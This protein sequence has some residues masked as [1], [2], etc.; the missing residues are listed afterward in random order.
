M[1]EKILAGDIHG[2]SRALSLVEGDGGQGT[3]DLLK[4]LYPHSSESLVVGITGGTGT[5]KSTLVEELAQEFLKTTQKVGIIAVDPTSPFSGGAI[6]GDRIRMQSLATNPAVF[7]RSMATRGRLGGLSAAVNDGLVVL[8]AAGYGVLLVETVGVGQ[9]EVEVAETADV[10]V[11]IL[12]PGMGDDVQTIKA[13]IM[14]IGDIFVLNKADRDGAEKARL[15]L[16]SLRSLM[17]PRDGWVPPILETVAIRGQGLS[18]LVSA[19]LDFESTV[20]ETGS[21]AKRKVAFCRAHLVDLLRDRLA[22]EILS[23]IGDQELH[24]YAERVAAHELDPY[25]AVEELVSLGKG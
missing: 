18:E 14:E 22:D 5:G 6:L 7:I 20:V 24:N 13:G 16:D 19:I 1:I 21:L 17:A 10:T 12:V 3:R 23:K 2:I 9:D 25:S 8:A 15:E 11:V 4:A